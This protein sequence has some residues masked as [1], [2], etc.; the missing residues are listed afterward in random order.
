MYDG[1]PDHSIIEHPC[2]YH[3]VGFCFHRTLDDT[4]ESYIDLSLQHGQV[5]RRLRFFSPRDVSIEEG[6]PEGS[7]MY[8]ADV[9]LR[10]LDGLGVRVGDFEAMGGAIRFWA[11][12]VIDLDTPTARS[13]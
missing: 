1:D 10:D 12:T 13:T 2:R 5:V 4:E 11:R 8:I 9:R 6:F 3:V 7:G